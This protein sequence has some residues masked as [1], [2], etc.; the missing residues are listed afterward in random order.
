MSSL[1]DAA[2]A[3]VR[4]SVLKT[5]G[6]FVLPEEK[7]RVAER[8]LRLVDTLGMKS[9]DDLIDALK[10]RDKK[11]TEKVSDVV[12][13]K[14]TSFFRDESAYQY[15]RQTVG[16][17]L[18][19]SR[20]KER[21]LK[22]W[23]GACSTGQ[24]A[25]SI[26]IMLDHA[27]PQ[28]QNWNVEIFATDI[29]TASIEKARRGVFEDQEIAT[30]INKALL[31]QHFAEDDQHWTIAQ[32]HKDRIQFEVLNLLQ[33]WGDIG[34][35]DIILLRNVLCYFEDGHRKRILDKLGRV[36][37]GDTYLFLGS[38]ERIGARRYGLRSQPDDACYQ[39]RTQEE[40][41]Q[42]EEQQ[43]TT[44]RSC[45][46]RDRCSLQELL[47]SNHIFGSLPSDLLGAIV[48]RFELHEFDH[49]E[50]LLK[51]G[52]RN[53]K[54]FILYEGEVVVRIDRGIFRRNLE[55]ARLSRG[56]VFGESSL[57]QN[58]PTTASVITDG[59]I[60]TFVADR[61][62]LEEL[63]DQDKSFKDYI[64][65]LHHDRWD[66][67]Q[68]DTAGGK[69]KSAIQPLSTKPLPKEV[70]EEFRRLVMCDAL[71][72]RL[73]ERGGREAPMTPETTDKFRAMLT[74]VSL[75]GELEVRHLDDLVSL[76]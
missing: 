12:I 29:S 26:S 72:R 24:E 35:F 53:D 48:D 55:L 8:L 41:S 21:T 44:Q 16:P 1:S 31:S 65:G 7:P 13:A 73:T 64:S 74:T 66:Q 30:G 5:A 69:T 6:I 23:C 18:A 50:T 61:S 52:E 70:P 37:H 2:F 19:E 11:V 68:N 9:V 17:K 27:M 45:E 38:G 4:A 32:R 58:K 49:S 15:L 43:T 36:M 59:P 25:Y 28:F 62:L 67:S 54:F 75:F 40:L 39:L 60:Q 42:P 71:R 14:D 20:G 34:P 47:S 63:C 33:D 46:P 76:V 57:L 22:V 51:Q 10:T 3:E 56:D